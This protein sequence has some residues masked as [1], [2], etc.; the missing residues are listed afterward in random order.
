M[1]VRYI[2]GACKPIHRKS[3]ANPTSTEYVPLCCHMNCTSCRTS[4]DILHHPNASK[5]GDVLPSHAL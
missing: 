5:F 3:M 1:C 4:G 2:Y